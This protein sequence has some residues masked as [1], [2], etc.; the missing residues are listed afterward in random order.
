MVRRAEKIHIPDKLREQVEAVASENGRDFDSVVSEMLEEGVRMRRFR[1]IWF[2]DEF[3]RREAKVFGT[4]LGVW[5]VIEGYK[6]AG[7]QWE[8]FKE[9]MSWLDESQLRDA[10]DYWNAYPDEI[11][12][13]VAESE[14]W[15][16]EKL[17][18]VY[19]WAKPPDWPP[20]E[21]GEPEKA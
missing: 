14:S 3:E 13:L 11:N 2:A 7:E 9:E 15:T 4:G 17:Y 18:S 8:A 10:L 1:G 16:E 19:P 21:R 6:R 12:E 20:A 5:E